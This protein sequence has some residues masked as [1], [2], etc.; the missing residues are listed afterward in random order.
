MRVSNYIPI[1][2]Q[3]A[4]ET[5]KYLLEKDRKLLL[6]HIMHLATTYQIRSITNLRKKKASG[7]RDQSLI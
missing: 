1:S 6:K 5:M 2:T 7:H 3:I 4:M